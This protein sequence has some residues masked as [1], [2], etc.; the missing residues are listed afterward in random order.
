MLAYIRQLNITTQNQIR[1]NNDQALIR[2]EEVRG[3]I[4][5]LTIRV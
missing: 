5:R 1:E 3:L 4:D 2:H